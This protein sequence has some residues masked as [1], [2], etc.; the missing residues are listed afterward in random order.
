MVN[1][2]QGRMSDI[3]NMGTNNKIYYGRHKKKN[4]DGL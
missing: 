1:L 4:I 3:Q 2:Y